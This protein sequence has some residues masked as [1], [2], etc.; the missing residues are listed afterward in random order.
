VEEIATMAL[1]VVVLM[2]DVDSLDFNGWKVI[3]AT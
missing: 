1:V 3:K 2:V